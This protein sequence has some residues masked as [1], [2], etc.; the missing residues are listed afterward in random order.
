MEFHV[1]GDN[2]KRR[3]SDRVSL[4]REISLELNGTTYTVSSGHNIYV[5]GEIR[6]APVRD[7]NGVIIQSDSSYTVRKGFLSS[8]TFKANSLHLYFH[9][10]TVTMNIELNDLKDYVDVIRR[11]YK[12]QK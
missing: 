9:V 2:A 5:N 10:V 3:P 6:T 7:F 4:L 1:W 12:K 11:H 8:S